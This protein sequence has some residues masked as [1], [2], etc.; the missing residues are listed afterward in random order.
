MA[1]LT[2]AT[3]TKP[4]VTLSAAA[5]ARL[6][7]IAAEEGRPLML[8]VAVEGGGCSVWTMFSRGASFR[9]A[10][11]TTPPPNVAMTTTARKRRTS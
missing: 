6:K 9:T 11:T 4:A 2:I 1:E 10:T 5:A 7:A 8:R 3:R